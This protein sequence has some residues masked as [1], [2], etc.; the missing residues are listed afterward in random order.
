M[1]HRRTWRSAEVRPTNPPLLQLDT[2]VVNIGEKLV[3]LDARGGGKFQNTS[4]AILANLAAA[5][6]RPDEIDMV[7]F[8]HAILTTRGV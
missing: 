1:R 4:G 8:T 3:L 5:G 6:Y 2:I 7:V